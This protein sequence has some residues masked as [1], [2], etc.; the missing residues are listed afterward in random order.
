M[1]L[2]EHQIDALKPLLAD[3]LGHGIICADTVGH[4]LVQAI[5]VLSSN[6]AVRAERLGV[7]QRQMERKRCNHSPAQ[8]SAY[9][10]KHSI[11]ARGR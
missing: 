2:T 5:E 7:I 9:E 10:G 11:L 1:K 6:E 8:L 3:Q 4:A